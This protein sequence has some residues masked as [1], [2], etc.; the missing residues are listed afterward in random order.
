MS[1]VHVFRYN[2]IDN[3]ILMFQFSVNIKVDIRDDLPLKLASL[4]FS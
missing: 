1:N 4:E 3:S 2:L